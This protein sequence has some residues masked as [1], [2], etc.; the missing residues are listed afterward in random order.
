MGTPCSRLI[1]SS[2]A[3]IMEFENMLYFKT[4]KFLDT[5]NI[6]ALDLKEGHVCRLTDARFGAFDPLAVKKDSTLYIYYSYYTPQRISGCTKSP[7]KIS[8]AYRQICKKNGKMCRSW[9][10]A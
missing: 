4:D 3:D 8:Y 9:P 2:L 10:P 5:D 1:S 7:H 6:Y